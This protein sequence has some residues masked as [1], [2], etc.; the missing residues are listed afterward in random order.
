MRDT[1]PGAPNFVSQAQSAVT[2]PYAPMGAVAMLAIMEPDFRVCFSPILA[3]F[4]LGMRCLAH[5]FIC[6][7]N[8]LR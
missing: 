1:M 5:G 8:S 2:R 7:L 6:A 3:R 4:R